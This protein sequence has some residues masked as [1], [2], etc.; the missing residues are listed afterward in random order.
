MYH[1]KTHEAAR[2]K[3][4]G[5]LS[6]LGLPSTA[7]T[8]KACACPLCGGKDRFRFD[9][10]DQRG[11]YI[12]NQCGAGD[13]LKLAIEFSGKPFR[14]ICDRVDELLGNIK[15]D[16]P[17]RPPMTD[18]AKR[19]ALLRIY[20]ATKPVQPGDLAHAYLTARGVDEVVYPDALRFGPAISDGEGGVRPC[21]VAM[22]GVHGDL[23]AKGQQ[24][25]VT[26]HRTF[27]K[28]DG[29]AKAEMEAPRKLMPGTV[30]DGACVMLSRYTG[31]ALGIA[32]G[33]E[34]AMSASA[35]YDIPVWA[36]IN[37]TMLAKW[38]PPEG[39]QEV[40]IFGDNDAKFGGQSAAYGLAHRLAVKGLA[41]TVH[42]PPN[43]G[44]DFNDIYRA[45]RR[46]ASK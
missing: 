18:E 26:M 8:G 30:P 24:R 3:W 28:P 2:G 21:L 27:L 15:P 40:A 37:S 44:E 29:S 7:L 39:C 16:A 10:K 45:T 11:T 31:G 35:L 9:N 12:C 33:I 14:E 5:I 46:G 38:T 23:T 1:Q 32:E 25:Y 17:G 42:F 34:T 22:V 41:V 13:G 4:K 36:A 43:P 19:E 20:A 6:E